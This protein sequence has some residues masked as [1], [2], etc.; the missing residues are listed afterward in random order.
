MKHNIL[1]ESDFSIGDT[2]CHVFDEEK[3]RKMLVNGI[4]IIQ[5]DKTGT[6]SYFT[7]DCSDVNGNL[8]GYKANELTLIEKVE[9]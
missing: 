3:E 9:Q 6:V 5:V 4:Y 1:I 8:Q 7:Y 2:V